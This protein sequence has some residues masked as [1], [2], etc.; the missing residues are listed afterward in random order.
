[1]QSL[2]PQY[3][4]V[5]VIKY[6]FLKQLRN[7][8]K[9]SF[10]YTEHILNQP[11][12]IDCNRHLSLQTFHCIH[13]NFLFAIVRIDIVIKAIVLSFCILVRVSKITILSTFYF[14]L[15]EIRY[16]TVLMYIRINRNDILLHYMKC[17]RK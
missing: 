12:E 6:I 10:D 16:C 3:L 11:E 17:S 5:K 15:N 13:F 1:M 8:S 2:F 4:N 9:V 7:K 14:G